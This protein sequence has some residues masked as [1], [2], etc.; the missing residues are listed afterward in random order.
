GAGSILATR[1]GL[2]GAGDGGGAVP[3][4]KL[5]GSAGAAPGS[6]T[7]FCGFFADATLAGA[8]V[9]GGGV[10][11][12]FFAGADFTGATSDDALSDGMSEKA[13]APCCCGADAGA[14]RTLTGRC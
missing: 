8:G 1:A 6:D 4:R 3:D 7:S 5:I 11:A 2:L 10:A 14:L 9:R 12:G 13:I